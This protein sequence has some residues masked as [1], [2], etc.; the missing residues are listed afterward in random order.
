MRRRLLPLA[1]VLALATAA[2]GCT[3]KQRK[4]I[5]HVKSDLIGLKRTVTLYDC[6]GRPIR[7]WRGRFKIEVQGAYLS[8]I[9]DDGH[10]V[11]VGGTV[12]V[13]EQ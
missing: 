5:K 7:T 1:F 2:S 4:G 13:E 8:F 12:V 9:D 3:E 10:E 11:K 6:N